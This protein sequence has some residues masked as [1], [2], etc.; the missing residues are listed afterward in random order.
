MCTK[1]IVTVDN[2]LVGGFNPF[3]K[4]VRQ[5]GSSPSKGE[6]KKFLKPPPSR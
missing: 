6:T 2:E 5:I 3:E 1:M 4:Y